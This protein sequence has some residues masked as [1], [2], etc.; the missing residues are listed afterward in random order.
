MRTKYF[1]TDDELL[2]KKFGMLTPIRRDGHTED[3]HRAWLCVCDC[4]KTVQISGSGLLN[5]KNKS[6]GC[7]RGKNATT[8]GLSK[9]SIYGVWKDMIRRCYDVNCKN[10]RY[11]GAKGI[12][13]CDEWKEDLMA[14]YNW[15]L[16][17]G[18]VEGLSIDRFPD[19]KGNYT[20]TN[21][22]WADRETQDNNRTDCRILECR[23]KKLTVTQFSRISGIAPKTIFERLDRGWDIENAIF[24]PPRFN[25]KEIQKKS[26]NQ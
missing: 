22:R 26:I 21:C 23:G 11:Y 24:D 16:E 18:W 2:G 10:Y 25:W 9:H 17:N 12:S 6:C 19:N 8:H 15:S 5:G 14:F 1:I 13:V 4:G 3:N 7:N 20:P